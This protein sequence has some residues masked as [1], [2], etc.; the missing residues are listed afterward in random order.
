MSENVQKYENW[1]AI[2]ELDYVTMFIKT[3]LAPWQG[4]SKVQENARRS[5][6]C[7]TRHAHRGRCRR[8]DRLSPKNNPSVRAEKIHIRREYYG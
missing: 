2:T 4:E 5:S 7:R 6:F 8:A 3:W 1:R